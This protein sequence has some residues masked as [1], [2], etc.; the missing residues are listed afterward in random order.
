MEYRKELKYNISDGDIIIL[1]NRI[2]KIMKLDSNIKNSNSYNIRS[3]YFDTYDYKYFSEN[4]AGVNERIKI[5]IRIYDKSDKII[6]LEIKSKKDGLIR[7][8]SCNI[9]RELC[10]KIIKGEMISISDCKNKKVLHKF[11][12]EQHI[13][14]LKPKI[15]V[16]YD[17]IAYTNLVGNVRITF[18]KN[19]K[20]SLKINDFFEN[21]ISARPILEIVNQILEIKYDELL[22]DY[23]FA[24]LELNKLSQV[25]FSKYYISMLQI[26]E[27]VL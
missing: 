27:S 14:L 23:I 21:N 24:S 8:E 15:I 19:I 1:E 4:E 5:R 10:E 6:K 20:S 12:I 2:K 18:D 11:Y 25:A 13:H 3:I 9:S 17:R 26:K 22:P 7:K 16:E